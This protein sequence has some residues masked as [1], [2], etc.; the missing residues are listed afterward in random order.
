MVFKL[1]HVAG[2]D[3]LIDIAFRAGAR[4]ARKERGKKDERLYR[5][6]NSDLARVKHA[7]AYI[8]GNL[9]AVVKHF[10]SYEQLTPFHQKLLDITVD[11][12]KFKKSLGAVDWCAKAVR[13]AGDESLRKIKRGDDQESKRFLGKAS[14][15]IKR[16]GRDLKFLQGVAKTLRKFPFVKDE[17]TI[18]V[19]G[20]PN[21]GK[22]T[23][24]KNLTD[25]K[26]KVATYP[27]TTTNVGLAYKKV[28]HTE[29]QLI[30]TP[31]LLDR[32]M[33]ERNKV[34]KA[35]VSALEELADEILF[36]I[37]PTQELDGQLRL[38][39]EIKENFKAPVTVA[40]N[41]A[42]AADVTELKVE[43]KLTFSALNP[44]DC[45]RIFK[46]LVRA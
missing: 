38:L 25:S 34:E 40:V 4:E 41:K 15:M 30:D 16:V 27:F 24:L 19:A 22:S 45:E 12:D 11:K 35:A 14:S 21:A 44:A 33:S 1:P 2:A 32:P 37:D 8:H 3:E 46:L 36:L 31:G 18:A 42:D 26:V 23:F 6:R 10:P 20:F 39:D 29:I 43:A 7:A 28:R 13:K 17:H 9:K 5:M